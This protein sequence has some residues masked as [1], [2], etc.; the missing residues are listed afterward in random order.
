[1]SSLRNNYLQFIELLKM[2][3][4]KEIVP[5][6]SK[7]IA[8]A[9]VVI[10]FFTCLI[11]FQQ[12][13]HH[14][15]I[16]DDGVYVT[17]NPYVQ[18]GLSIESIKWAFTTLTAEFWQPLTW[19]SYMVDVQIY[20][21]NASGFLITNFFIHLANSLFL[22]FTFQIMTNRLWISFFIA[23]LFAVHPIHVETVSWISERKELLCGL[24]WILSTLFY[25]LYAISLKKKYLFFSFSLFI[26]GIM[27]KTMIVTMP[28]TFL[29][30]DFCFFDRDRLKGNN[31]LKRW[32]RLALEKIPFFIISFLGCLITIIAQRKNDGIVSMESFGVFDRI[33]NI[34]VSYL[35]YIIKSF[36]PLNYSV[37][38]PV[39][40]KSLSTVILS[41]IVIL[42][43]TVFGLFNYR[44]NNWFISGWFW[45]LGTLV[46]VI[47]IVKIGDFSMADRYMY[48]PIIGIFI[49]F[50]FGLETIK[51]RFQIRK[52]IFFVI[53]II[54]TC[55][56]II[57]SF[58]Q[59]KKWKDSETLFK[60]SLSVTESN[61]LASHALGELYA[62]QG[63]MKSAVLNFQKAVDIRPDKSAFW[64][65]LGRTQVAV[66]DLS[67]SINS[68]EKALYLSPQKPEPHFYLLCIYLE[69]NNIDMAED[70]FQLLIQKHSSLNNKK[71]LLDHAKNFSEKLRKIKII[72]DKNSYRRMI[73]R[74]FDYW[75][76]NYQKN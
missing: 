14:F 67:N 27:S 5:D 63:D 64:M 49:I 75:N 40:D 44:K 59:V 42:C 56:L 31:V 16:L 20:G 13:D 8:I 26:F 65:K 30:L 69:K 33:A 1:M 29:I 74:G 50:I 68:F 23:F 24:F 19:I 38:Y 61:Y 21:M 54:I 9:M 34:F 25:S 7:N 48:M 22:F 4:K 57:S 11:Y 35:A 39:Q 41:I 12:F 18:K 17:N 60:H 43:I 72:K 2:I 45:F 6:K 28:F 73:I 47:G 51:L 37:F 62:L 53:P 66:K 58:Y 10:S 70:Q 71:I 46:P 15:L 76:K 36:W 55:P 32:G 3:T 52:I